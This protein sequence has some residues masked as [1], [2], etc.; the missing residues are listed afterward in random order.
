M[1]SMGLMG[2]WKIIRFLSG[3]WW[4]RAGVGA[5]HVLEVQPSYVR[6]KARKSSKV[7]PHTPLLHSQG[8]HDL[9]YSFPKSQFKDGIIAIPEALADRPRLRTS[10]G[11]RAHATKGNLPC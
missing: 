11:N 1:G 6:V 8:L 3:S 2:G 5:S 10:C 7:S 9:A 4:H